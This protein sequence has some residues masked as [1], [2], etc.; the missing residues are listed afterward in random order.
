M[1]VRG[2]AK[3]RFVEVSNHE[4]RTVVWIDIGAFCLEDGKIVSIS[5]D[6]SA[7]VTKEDKQ[8]V[9]EYSEELN[10]LNKMI[11]GG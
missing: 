4:K 6:H 7:Y 11:C 8:Y 5:M 1:W 9:F 10:E 2:V 3:L